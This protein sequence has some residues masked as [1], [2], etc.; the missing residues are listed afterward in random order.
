M[1]RASLVDVN[2]LLPA[3][4]PQHPAHDA[5]HT[6][7]L[8]RSDDAVAYWAWPT[9]LGVLRLLSQPRVMG[10]AALAP[11]RALQTWDALVQATGLQEIATTP[12]AHARHLRALVAGRA[13]SPNLWTDAWLAALALSLD[14]EMVSFDR[15]FQSFA[16]LALKLLQA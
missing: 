4:L 11:E 9:Q 8:Q 15:G 5:A 13:A 2:V 10:S 16:G 3:L 6:W 12:S 14:C 1:T 7:L